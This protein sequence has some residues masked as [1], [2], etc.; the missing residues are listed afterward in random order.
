MTNHKLRTRSLSALMATAMVAVSLAGCGAPAKSES[1][2][3]SSSLPAT[4]SSAS[5]VSSAPESKAEGVQ[6]PLTDQPVTLT[7][8]RPL[9][10]SAAKYIT[11]TSETDSAVALEK[12]TG[13]HVEYTH[14]PVGQESTSFS[15]L[16]ASGDYPDITQMNNVEYPGGGDAA[17]NDGVF[18]KLNDL[19]DKYAPD[20][21]ALRESSEEKRKMTITDNGNI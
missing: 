6:L 17:L 7:V 20:Y 13:V 1:S 21:K 18:L 8:W 19:I 2:T 10:P 9:H 11:N 12:A 16:L 5:A 3:G 14:P 15:I 4:A